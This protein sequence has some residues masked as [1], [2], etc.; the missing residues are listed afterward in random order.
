MASFDVFGK[1]SSLFAL[2]AGAI[3]IVV[4]FFPAAILLMGV[5]ALAFGLIN[6]LNS[7]YQDIVALIA[8]ILGI[9]VIIVFTYIWFF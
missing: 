7:K 3:A 9:I 6:F 5:L 1:D 2:I 4:I 8:M